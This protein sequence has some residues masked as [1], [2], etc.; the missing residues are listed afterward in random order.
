MEQYTKKVDSKNVIFI[1]DVSRKSGYIPFK[2]D[3]TKNYIKQL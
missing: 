1:R 2:F 3:L